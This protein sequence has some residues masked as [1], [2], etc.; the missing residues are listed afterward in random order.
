MISFFKKHLGSLQLQNIFSATNASEE[1]A[2]MLSIK[3]DDALFVVQRLT[4]EPGGEL[5]SCVCL[6]YP[7]RF[8][9]MLTII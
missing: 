1:D 8:Y 5:V 6:Y 4:M 9:Q 2:E 7:G 3:K